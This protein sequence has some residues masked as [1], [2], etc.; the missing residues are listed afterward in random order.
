[1]K[2][3]PIPLRVFGSRTPPGLKADIEVLA[4]LPADKFNDLIRAAESFSFATPPLPQSVREKKIGEV[5]K[6]TGVDE[7]TLFAFM[8]V[9]TFFAAAS[10]KEPSREVY[11]SESGRLGIPSDRAGTFWD[12]FQKHRAFMVSNVQPILK[13]RFGPILSDVTWRVDVP[14]D[15]SPPF[16][17]E[18]LAVVVL[19]LETA[20]DS[21]SVSIEL[22][23]SSA[24]YLIDELTK[25]KHSLAR[26]TLKDR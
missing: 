20:T 24:E 9:Y 7:T 18:P 1:M 22:D 23:L 17:A 6:S 26:A 8:R 5:T 13:E 3:T 25:A 16:D 10:V 14:A 4:K 12:S 15:G 19:T 11:V 21:E 2:A